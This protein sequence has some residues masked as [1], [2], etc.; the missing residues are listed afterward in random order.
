[1]SFTLALGCTDSRFTDVGEVC[2]GVGFSHIPPGWGWLRP[3]LHI[4]SRQL[5]KPVFDW[6]AHQIPYENR[7]EF[8]QLISP[9]TAA[10]PQTESSG[11]SLP[12][13]PSA[14]HSLG[15]LP[16]SAYGVPT[17]YCG[18]GFLSCPV[19]TWNERHKLRQYVELYFGQEAT[20]LFHRASTM[21]MGSQAL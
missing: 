8:P 17:D 21:T 3:S 14:S 19:Q 5:L 20:C 4:G 12:T 13:H 11:T 2:L 18:F 7:R 9:R 15:S 1:M 10:C 16:F 6:G